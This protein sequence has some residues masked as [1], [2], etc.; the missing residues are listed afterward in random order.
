MRHPSGRERELMDKV[1]LAYSGGLDTSVAIKW[2]HETYNLEVICVTVD[3]GNER[4]FETIQEKALRTGATKAYVHDAK[5][6]FVNFFV[7]PSLQAGTIYEGQY[8]LATALARPLIAKIMVDYARQEGA[9]HVAHGCTGKG[10]D[11]VRFDVSFNA[12]APDLKIVA[13]DRERRRA[14]GRADPDRAAQRPGRLARNRADRPRREPLRRDQV[15]R[16]LR[17]PGRYRTAQGP[18]RAGDADAHA[19][20]DALQADGLERA[21]DPDIQR[22]LVLG[23]HPGP[24]GVRHLDAAVRQWH[25][26]RQ[27][28]QRRMHHRRAEGRKLAVQRGTGD[29]WPG[30]PVRPRSGGRVHQG[31]RH[32]GGQS[33]VVAV[34]ARGRRDR[35][36]DAP[37]GRPARRGGHRA[38]RGQRE[39][40][41]RLMAESHNGT[42][43]Y[44][45]RFTKAQAAG[46]KAINDSLPVDRR[47]YDEDIVGSIAHARMLG[48]QGI[49]PAEDARAI[50]DGLARLHAELTET[51]G[52][53]A[54]AADED[55]HSF[56][57]RR[58]GEMVGASA[59]RLHTARSRNDQVANDLRMWTRGAICDGIAA[60]LDLQAALLNRAEGDKGLILPGYTHVQRGQPVLLSHHWLAYVEMLA[61]DIGRLEDCYGRTDVMALGAGALAGSPYPLDREYAASLLG[62]GN[63]SANSMDAVA[64]RDFVVEHLSALALLA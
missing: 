36:D 60:A 38:D 1:I 37:G 34:A 10:N 28:V 43:L 22:L 41:R 13:P 64:D 63:V 8:P 39:G 9:S 29:L 6:D 2:L 59:G 40:R 50:V 33:G 21:G 3:V 53:P 44:A 62:F 47:M 42:T 25:G 58:L 16:D 17:V 32:G 7:F 45:S 57:E 19:R 46:L 52:V 20:S 12:L 4:D 61:R 35:A 55:I 24:D 14:P 15:A 11:Q 54:D 56:V 48:R 5:Q 31:G 51:G 18:R 49:I 30:R 26:A 27:A 23:A